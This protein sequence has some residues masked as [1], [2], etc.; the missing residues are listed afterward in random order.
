MS[1]PIF[2]VFA[3]DDWKSTDSMRLV[4]ATTSRAKLKELV[5]TCV[6]SERFEYGEDSVEDAATQLRKDFE[7]GLSIYDI[8]NNLRFGI[9]TAAE[10]GEM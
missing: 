9:I 5:A 6:E 8:N 7:S 2:I 1:S 10:D 3:C 4:S